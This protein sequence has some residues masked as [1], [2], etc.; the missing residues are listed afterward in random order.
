[1][2]EGPWGSPTE[3][4]DRAAEAR[5]PE[6]AFN[7]RP[8]QA[9]GV[10]LIVA[11]IGLTY[12]WQLTAPDPETEFAAALS[13][14]SIAEGRWQTLFTS[15]FM[16]G[17][18]AHLV[19]NLSALLPFG[20][21]VARRM[22]PTVGGQL[23]FLVFYLLAGLAGNGVWLLMGAGQGGAVVGASGAIFGLWA[24]VLRMRR[25]GGP[26]YP[27]FS[28]EV[29]RQMVG[30]LIA[31]VLVTVAFGVMTAGSGVGGIAWQAHLGG[32]LFG[33]ATIGL[34]LPPRQRV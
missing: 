15:M 9:W 29:A 33:L 27:L 3:S 6:P 17:G 7:T 19:M 32:F 11:L 25:D 30:P 23:R 12:L 22:G 16:H 21:I 28:W 8:A 13:A 18:V 31:N 20:L 5:T 2:T 4:A 14:R 1:M 26:L 34:F 24:A 10:F